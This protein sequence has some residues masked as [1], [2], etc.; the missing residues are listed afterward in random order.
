M[1]WVGRVGGRIGRG[2][3]KDGGQLSVVLFGAGGETASRHRWCLH[4][5]VATLKIPHEL[6]GFNLRC[7]ILQRPYNA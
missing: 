4:R 6:P 3:R 7:P 5:N 1:P 2:R